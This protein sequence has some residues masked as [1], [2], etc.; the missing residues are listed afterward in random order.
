MIKANTQL[1]RDIIKIL[2]L[3]NHFELKNYDIAKELTN[4]YKDYLAVKKDLTETR[5][6]NRLK[7]LYYY[8]IL[9]KFYDN[10][11][12][13][14]SLAGVKRA[15]LSGSSFTESQ[16]VLSKSKLILLKYDLSKCRILD[17]SIALHQ[18]KCLNI[19]FPTSCFSIQRYQHKGLL[20]RS[21]L[22]LNIKNMPNC[23]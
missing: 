18:S 10:K 6:E 5:R 14:E 3:K 17:N 1:Y 20:K 16:W 7:F 12:T 23:E 13:K 4:S 2:S 15:I 21:P 19:Y 11:R 22:E 8:S 9:W